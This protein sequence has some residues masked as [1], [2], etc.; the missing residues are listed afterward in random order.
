MDYLSE[1]TY[2]C[3]LVVLAI[4]DDCLCEPASHQKQ[5]H[6]VGKRPVVFEKITTQIHVVLQITLLDTVYNSASFLLKLGNK[7]ILDLGS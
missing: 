6:D 2:I 7:L 1:F 5:N 3:V 4:C